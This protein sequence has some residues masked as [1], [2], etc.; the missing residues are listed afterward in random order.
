MKSDYHDA[1]K[2]QVPIHT[3]KDKAVTL[4]FYEDGLA[5]DELAIKLKMA[6]KELAEKRKTLRLFSSILMTLSVL[7]IVQMK[8]HSGKHLRLCLG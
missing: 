7:C 1:C 8:N 2:W 5:D 3:L 4:Y 6:Y